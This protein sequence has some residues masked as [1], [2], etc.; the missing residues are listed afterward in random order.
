MSPGGGEAF[1]IGTYHQKNE[2]EKGS[3]K[4]ETERMQL[5]LPRGS[6]RKINREEKHRGIRKRK[7]GGKHRIEARGQRERAYPCGNLIHELREERATRSPTRMHKPPIKLRISHLARYSLHQSS[8]NVD[9]K[10]LIS[11]STIKKRSR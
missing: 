11:Y 10:N 8:S 3:H 5:G 7:G 1:E 2:G 4:Y 9:W 6:K